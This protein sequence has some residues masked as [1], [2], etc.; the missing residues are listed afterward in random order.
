MNVKYSSFFRKGQVGD[1]AN[2]LAISLAK[3]FDELLKEKL[4]D[5][6]L[7]FEIFTSTQDAP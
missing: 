5:S 4:G 2:D 7:T 3:S 6:G 1:W